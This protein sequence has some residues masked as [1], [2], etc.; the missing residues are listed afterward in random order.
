MKYVRL[1][2]CTRLHKVADGYDSACLACR[3]DIIVA[4]VGVYLG[5][6]FTDTIPEGA[7]LCRKCFPEEKAREK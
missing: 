6:H 3:S 1:K 2:G 4:M 7:R 5:D